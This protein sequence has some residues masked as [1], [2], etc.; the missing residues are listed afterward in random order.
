MPIQCVSRHLFACCHTH[1]KSQAICRDT[2][3]RFNYVFVSAPFSD[4]TRLT[5]DFLMQ[6]RTNQR[7]NTTVFHTMQLCRSLPA[8]PR[9]S[10]DPYNRFSSS[11]GTRMRCPSES[12]GTGPPGLVLPRPPRGGARPRRGPRGQIALPG[13]APGETGQGR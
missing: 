7:S 9:A 12:Q 4:T 2:T 13:G 10:S 5:W 8:R 11:E 3:H 6:R 1:S